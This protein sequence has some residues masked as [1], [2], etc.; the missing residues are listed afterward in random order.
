MVI[1]IMAFMIEVYEVE[2]RALLRGW[3]LLPSQYN[4]D[5]EHHRLPFRTDWTT[6]HKPIG[7]RKADQMIK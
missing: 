1:E 2:V 4:R 6:P 7:F 5:Q 3:Y